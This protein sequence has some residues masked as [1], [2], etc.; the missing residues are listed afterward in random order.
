MGD[1]EHWNDRYRLNGSQSVSW[2]EERPSVSLALLDALGVGPAEAVIDV[3][4]G[5]S[6]LVDHLL[7][8]GYVDLTVLDISVTALD[9]ARGRLGDPDGVNWVEADILEWRPSGQW[10]VW[11][12]RA[13]LHFLVDDAHRSDYVDTLRR[14]LIPGGAFVIG[15]FA[16]DG[17]T[18]CSG[19]PV[20]RQT[21][22]DLVGLLGDVEILEQ[23][24]QIHRTPDDAEQPFTWIA[25][26]LPLP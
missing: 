14:S 2:Y 15:T 3:G 18:T 9:T 12:D 11:H 26:R 5:A 4:G 16:E 20:W 10:N 19:L 22:E 7:G 24:R 13:V 25:G 23:R 8:A 1:P 17:P 21:G 6:T